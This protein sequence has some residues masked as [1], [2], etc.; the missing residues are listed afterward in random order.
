MKKHLWMLAVILAMGL[1]AGSCETEERGGTDEDLVNLLTE[2]A[3]LAATGE[4]NT[5]ITKEGDR[6]KVSGTITASEDYP[7]LNMLVVNIKAD[8][9]DAGKYFAGTNR[10]SITC[11]FPDSAV[12]PY[13]NYTQGLDLYFENIKAT[14]NTDRFE[15][16]WQSVPIEE[17]NAVKGVGTMTVDRKLTEHFNANTGKN[18]VGDYH[19]LVIRLKF[20]SAHIGRD[21]SFYISNAGVFGDKIDNMYPGSE[22]PIIHAN[23]RLDNAE[24]AAGDTADALRIVPAFQGP[25]P[26]VTPDSRTLYTYKWYSNTADSATGGALIPEDQ[27]GSN[28]DHPSGWNE[29]TSFIPPTGTAG[30]FY[31]YVVIISQDN[32]SV[33]SRVVTITVNE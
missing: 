29:G 5:A 2:E 15:G 7:G 22:T 33:T 20:P 19:H 3:I 1:A 8:P 27:I 4:G 17:Y 18:N 10:Y 13:D 25:V 28:N 32:I 21:Y 24:Y 26:D 31:Y 12:K 16:S 11:N 14:D 9:E 30:T 23:S 6:Y